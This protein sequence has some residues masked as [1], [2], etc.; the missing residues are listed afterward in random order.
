MRTDKRFV[1]EYRDALISTA[2]VANEMDR[3]QIRSAAITELCLHFVAEHLPNEDVSCVPYLMLGYPRIVDNLSAAD[4]G[5]LAAIRHLGTRYVSVSAWLDACRQHGDL[6]ETLRVYDIVDRKPMLRKAASPML[7]RF[8]SERLNQNVPWVQRR[9]SIAGPG[10]AVVAV[11]RGQT[12]LSY[13]I[14]SMPAGVAS[15]LNK[16]HLSPRTHNPPIQLTFEQMRS[17]AR[18]VDEREGRDDWPRSLPR[19]RL[20]ERFTRLKIEGLAS[21]FLQGETMTLEGAVHLVGMLS[22]GKSTLVWVLIFALTHVD[23]RKRIAMLV[24]DTIQAATVVSRLRLHGIRASVLSSSYNR[25]R[26]LS[27]IH[28]QQGIMSNGWSLSSMGDIAQGFSV[29]CPLDGMQPEPRIIRGSQESAGFPNFNEKPCHRIYLKTYPQD[30]S[31]ANDHPD[32][33]P[34]VDD[35]KS[36]SCPLWT[37]CPAQEQQRSAVDAEVLVMTAQAFVHMTP[38]KWVSD[39]NITI[40]ELVQFM[41]DLVIV[42]EVDGMQKTMDEIFAPRSPIMGDELSVYAPAIGSRSAEALRKRSGIQFRREVNTKWQAN[43]H[44]FFRLIGVIYALLQNE[45]SF[46]RPFY[47]NKPFT[48]A[49]ILYDLWRRQTEK[50]DAGQPGSLL[51]DREIESEFLEVMKVAS[52]ISRFSRVSSIAEEEIESERD[53]PLTFQNPQFQKAAEALQNVAREILV[54]DYYK[55]VASDVEA[56]LGDELSIFRAAKQADGEKTSKHVIDPRA[57]ALALLLA[58]VTEL[59]LSHYNWLIKTQPAVATAFGI[60]DA[61]LLSQANNLIRHYRTLLPWNPAGAIFGFF[62]DTPTPEKERSMGGKLTLINHLGVG[63]YLIAH[64]H[65][66]LAAEGQAGPHV[67]MLSGTS[68]AGGS[69]RRKSRKTGK[70]IDAASPSFDVQVPVKGVLLQPDAEL[71]AIKKSVFSLV[72]VQDEH[73]KQVR[74]SGSSS[75]NERRKILAFTAQRLVTRRDETNLIEENWRRSEIRWGKDDIEDRRRALLVVNSYADAHVVSDAL[76]ETLEAYGYSDWHVRCLVRDHGDDELPPDATPRK[77]V[78]ELPRSLVESFGEMPEKSLLV[79]PMVVVARGHNILN[80]RSK[81]AISAI[82]FLHRPHPR[83]EDLA[84]IIGRLNRFAL[85]RF[86]KGLKSARNQ[87]DLPLSVRARRM[88]HAATKIVRLSLDLRSGY[89]GLPAEYKA[90]FAWDMLTPLWQ[91]IGRGIR[92]GCPV[93]VG[94]IDRQFAPESFDGRQ[95]TGDSSVLVQTIEQLEDAMDPLTNKLEYEVARLLYGPFH[96]ALK[97]TKGLNYG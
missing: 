96:D 10:D 12:L 45:E 53:E 56:M 36:H 48:A 15:V 59:A 52:A 4:V 9:L 51:Q 70:P 89:G 95:D 86:D 67:L 92:N 44:A 55:D 5:K 43:F 90:Q 72:H 7:H 25:D 34:E 82:Y 28:W 91:T 83:P 21:G 62:Y 27:S 49:S 42:D 14:P 68:W 74:I 97:Q 32:G 37:S 60:D 50:S 81:A 79:A 18:R 16:Y 22:S 78:R 85:E 54:A 23:F 6:P 31:I 29:A 11:D 40:P 46:L 73:G 35:E 20:E 57:N 30:S 3:E 17:A 84:P 65:D 63:R 69:V 19:L 58:I 75:E 38:D 93:S 64:L 76:L 33:S 77:R 94:F 2:P 41:R 8:L 88:R 71:T 87:P 66:L 80:H 61:Q 26:H 24:T 1:A 47:K 13:R 39:N